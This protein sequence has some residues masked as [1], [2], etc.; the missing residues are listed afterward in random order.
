MRNIKKFESFKKMNE[1]SNF[2]RRLVSQKTKSFWDRRIEKWL[3]NFENEDEQDMFINYLKENPSEEGRL[4]KIIDLSEKQSNNFKEILFTHSFWDGHFNLNAQKSI[5]YL[6][7]ILTTDF[8]EVE[9]DLREL[10]LE[11][12]DDGARVQV[13]SPKSFFENYYTRDNLFQ[14][15]LKFSFEEFVI[16]LRNFKPL[17]D[18]NEILTNLC[19]RCTDYFNLPQIMT[20]IKSKPNF[21][22][23]KYED[24]EYLK[25]ASV[26]GSTGS[27]YMGGKPTRVSEFPYGSD[28][29][30]F[31]PIYDPQVK[32]VRKQHGRI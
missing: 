10:L 9:N 4:L 3:E 16:I 27:I 18:Y 24:G 22:L 25:F 32:W 30:M 8:S 15:N 21:Q 12:T 11:I 31:L 19:D 13:L 7:F 23:I 2:T 17:E 6:E 26:E 5:K 28:V 20:A 29:F 14:L 1:E